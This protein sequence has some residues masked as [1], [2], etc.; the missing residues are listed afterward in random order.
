MLKQTAQAVFKKKRLRKAKKI[1]SKSTERAKKY[2][3]KSKLLKLS[4]DS[5]LCH[6][7]TAKQWKRSPTKVILLKKTDY[8]TH[9]SHYL[10]IAVQL[11]VGT[12]EP[13]LSP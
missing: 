11:G 9:K 12:H 7:G 4:I 3:N 2:E 5:N 13:L 1:N 8:L 10:S 6:P